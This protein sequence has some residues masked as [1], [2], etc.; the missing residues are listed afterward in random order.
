MAFLWRI[1]KAM[2]VV[3]NLDFKH[4]AEIRDLIKKLK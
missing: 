3:P 1:G 4:A 2:Q